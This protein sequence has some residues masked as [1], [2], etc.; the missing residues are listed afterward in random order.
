LVVRLYECANRR[1]PFSLKFP[2]PVRSAAGVNLLE[3]EQ[4]AVQIDGDG[5]TIQGFIRPFEIKTFLI[6]F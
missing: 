5:Q 1:G 6:N 4:A 2:F 3:E